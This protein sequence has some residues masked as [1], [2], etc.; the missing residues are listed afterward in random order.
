MLAVAVSLSACFTTRVESGVAGAGFPHE[1]RQ[2]FTAGGLV[3]LSTPAGRE[4][5]SGIAMAESKIGVA[6]FII[7]TLLA[8]GGGVAGYVGCK[9]QGPERQA[10]CFGSAFTL[11]PFIISSRTVSYVCSSGPR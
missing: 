3:N 11:A 9:A 4:C 8:V 7:D 5:Q 1:D 10:E 2:W 6:D